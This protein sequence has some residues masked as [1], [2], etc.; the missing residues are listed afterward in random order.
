MKKRKINVIISTIYYAY[1]IDKL[2]N[3]YF[4]I[5]GLISSHLMQYISSLVP[6]NFLALIYIYILKA[7]SIKIKTLLIYSSNVT[8]ILYIPIN[9]L[10]NIERIWSNQR[11]AVA[12]FFI[13]PLTNI[14]KKTETN[15]IFK[16]ISKF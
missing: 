14:P 1:C 2:R 6:R 5:W 4:K 13:T 7:G 12:L 11:A 10:R 9:N 15:K 16:K 8:K 3:S